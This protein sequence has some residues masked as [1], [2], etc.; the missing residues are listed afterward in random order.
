MKDHLT[1]IYVRRNSNRQ[2]Y[3]VIIRGCIQVWNPLGVQYARR[4]LPWNMIWGNMREYI[5]KKNPLAAQNATWN[6]VTRVTVVRQIFVH[7]ATFSSTLTA[8]KSA[9]LMHK[10]LVCHQSHKDQS[11]SQLT[12]VIACFWN[13]AIAITVWMQWRIKVRA[14]VEKSGY[15][16]L[17]WKFE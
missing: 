17:F 15:L 4:N 2:R 7:M 11:S 3:C 8:S 12:K 5:Q 14:L 16:Q 6:S 13:F 9:S 10:R 1:A